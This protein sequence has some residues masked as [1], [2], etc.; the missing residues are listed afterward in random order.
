MKTKILLSMLI[1]FAWTAS[2]SAQ[3]ITREKADE[4]VI[5][6]AKSELTLSPS[7]LIY[8]N[9]NTPSAEDFVIT[10]STGETVKAKYACWVYAVSRLFFEPCEG[11]VGVDCPQY[12]PPHPSI[13]GYRY[14]FVK[15]DGG[16]LLE[17]ITSSDYGLDLSSW[18]EVKVPRGIAAPTLEKG[19]IIG[20]Y[21]LMGVKLPQEPTNGIYIIVYDNGTAKKVLK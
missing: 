1:L 7:Q 8:L 12:M 13:V 10:T 17:V 15:E 3:K 4:I 16:S 19:E 5:N 21:N 18:T 2:L 14:L 20:Y 9:P 6:Y 11:V